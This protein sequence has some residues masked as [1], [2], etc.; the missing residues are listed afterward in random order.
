[1]LSLVSTD[2][3]PSALR[4]IR[5]YPPGTFRAFDKL[6]PPGFKSRTVRV[7][8]PSIYKPELPRP[9]LFM[10]DGQ[11]TYGDAGSF[12]GGWHLHEAADKLTSKKVFAPIVVGLD[13]GH[14]D[15]MSELSAFDQGGAK[16]RAADFMAWI[17]GDVVPMIRREYNLLP[18]AVGASVGGSSLGGLAALYCHYQH[19]ATFGGAL[20]MSPSFWVGRQAIFKWIEGRPRPLYSRVYLDCG[21]KEGGGRMLALAER[22]HRQLQARGYSSKQLMWRPDSRGIHSESHWRRRLPKALRFMFRIGA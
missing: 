5:S 3:R 18:G 7:Y 15:R 19:P 6:T 1:M 21:A 12:A 10:F 4:I 17:A 20:C 2:R 8:V 22:M 11:N 14:E 13:H 16:G 9:A